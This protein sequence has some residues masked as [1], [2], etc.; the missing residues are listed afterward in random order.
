MALKFVHLEELAEV[1]DITIDGSIVI[2]IRSAGFHSLEKATVEG[3]MKV[4]GGFAESGEGIDHKNIVLR[5][6]GDVSWSMVPVNPIVESVENLLVGV[7]PRD[8]IDTLNVVAFCD[9]KA[10]V[11]RRKF[12]WSLSFP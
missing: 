3:K 2:V 9:C 12:F 7:P 6:F 10:A 5:P 8:N 1:E 4:S 11:A